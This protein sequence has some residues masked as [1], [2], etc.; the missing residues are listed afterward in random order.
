MSLRAQRIV[1]YRNSLLH[2]NLLSIYYPILHGIPP[3][4]NFCDTLY[5]M[6]RVLVMPHDTFSIFGRL[7]CVA[8]ISRGNYDDARARI[9]TNHLLYNFARAQRV[10]IFLFVPPEHIWRCK[11]IYLTPTEFSHG[12]CDTFLIYAEKK[13]L[14]RI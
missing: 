1:H 10:I 3:R 9:V 4:R 11:A 8:H 2:Y 12:G 5:I 13:K 7:F 14:A 6:S